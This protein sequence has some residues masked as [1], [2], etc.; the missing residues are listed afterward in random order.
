MP[1]GELVAQL[2]ALIGLSGVKQEVLNLIN[3]VK[4]RKLRAEQG[5][6]TP[7]LS[8]HLVFTGNPGT[9]KTTVARLIGQL[10]HALGVLSHGHV[11]EVDRSG[12]V[13]GYVGQTALKTREVIQQALGGVLFIDEAY[14]LSGKGDN[15]YGQEAIDTLLKAM[16][17]HRDNLIVIVAGYKEPM[18]EFINSNPGLR[19]R[20]NRYIDFAD[21]GQGELAEILDDLVSRHGY[22]LSEDG[23]QAAEVIIQEIASQRNVNFANGRDIRN[24][25]EAS[26][27]RQ[28]NRI[29]VL[30]DPTRD[31]LMLIA[32]PD[33]GVAV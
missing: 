23:R 16:E 9:G 15:D 20:F 8:L 29:S 17:D 14:A 1:E 13:G 31:D 19:S 7:P 32:G 10:Y 5:L 6:P 12:L 22:V 4:V 2:Q 26:I 11:R 21:Y 25:F 30:A 28:A 24:L 33:V 3:L 27:V 18:S